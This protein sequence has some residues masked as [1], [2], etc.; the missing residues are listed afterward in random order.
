MGNIIFNRYPIV[1]TQK[2]YYPP[3]FVGSIIRAGV[4]VGGDTVDIITTRLQ[5]VHFERNEYKQLN[6]IKSGTDRELSG[7]KNIIAKLRLGYKR[8]VEQVQIVKELISRSNRP[9]IF[10][11]DLNDIPV[12]YTYAEIRNKLNDAWVKKGYG[13]GRT[14]VYIS[15]TLR[16]DQIF[17]NS[18]FTASQVKRIFAEGATDHHALVADLTLKK[19]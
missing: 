2:I 13:L 18:Q 11:G 12:S 4:M 1:D 6:D 15:P 10:T 9:L 19:K 7:L 14:F 5:S 17:Y 16:I 8:R 3:P